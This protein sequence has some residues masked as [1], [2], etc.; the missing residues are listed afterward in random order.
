MALNWPDSCPACAKKWANLNTFV[1][2]NL[3]AVSGIAAITESGMCPFNLSNLNEETR[4]VVGAGT[5]V[6][7]GWGVVG[8]NLFQVPSPT[9]PSAVKPLAFW[10]AITASWEISIYIS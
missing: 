4:I 10:K 3:A 8:N 2:L 7:V 1:I 6:E 5:A 9:I